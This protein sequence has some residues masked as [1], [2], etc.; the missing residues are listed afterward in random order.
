MVFIG[1]DHST[2]MVAAIF[3]TLDATCPKAGGLDQNFCSPVDK[4][5]IVAGS[6]PIVPHSE[7]HI[8]T[9]VLL[10][11]SGEEANDFTVGATPNGGVASSPLSAD[12]MRRG[13]PESK[14]GRFAACRSKRVVTVHDQSARRLRIS[15][16]E[17]RQH[18]N[19]GVPEHMPLVGGSAQ[20]AGPNG[21]AIVLRVCRTQQMIDGKAQR[22]LRGRIALDPKVGCLPSCQPGIPVLADDACHVLD[23]VLGMPPCRLAR[24]GRILEVCKAT[25]RSSR[26]VLPSRSS[27]LCRPSTSSGEGVQRPA[28]SVMRRATAMATIVPLWVTRT[29]GPLNVASINSLPLKFSGVIVTH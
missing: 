7:G 2:N 29:T 26:Y 17:K 9:D 23:R 11:L 14:P 6:S 24:L 18:K 27:R 10:L 16:Y 25:I 8:C 1:P 4:K 3:L 22:A 20:S 21:H 12:S 13:R 5:M 15:E 19:V 28:V